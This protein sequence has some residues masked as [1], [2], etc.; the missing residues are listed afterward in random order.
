VLARLVWAL[1]LVV[2]WLRER[3]RRLRRP[4]ACV[5]FLLEAPPPEPEAPRPPL[6]QRATG[7]ARQPLSV[8]DLARQLRAVTAEPRVRTVVLHLR[9]LEMAAAQVDA[10]R[11]L[12]AEVRAAGVRVVCWAPSYSAS[13][14][15][16]A[17]AADEVLMQAGGT[18][19]PLG[20]ARE[21]VFLAD[22][23]D[24]LGLRVDLLQVSPY[25]T[26]GDALTRRGLTPEAREMAG[27]LAD[28]AY[29]DRLAAIASGRRLDDAGAR[30][31]ADDSPLVDDQ[32][33]AAG[34]VDALIAEEDLPERLG[35]EVRPWAAARRRLPRPRPR[36]PGRVVALLRIEGLIVDGRSRHAPFRLPLAPP[37]LF[38]EQCGDLTVVEQARALA[39]DR[40]VGAVVVWVDSGGG[41]A[42][43]SEAMAAALAALGRRKPVV[44]AMGAV[45]AS[46]G[47]YV[48]ASAA[49][50]FAH[51]GTVTGS[52]G[53]LAG[54][55]VA[56]RLLDHLLVGREHVVRGEH[57]AMW[58]AESPFTD[59][60]RRKLGE[61]IDRSYGLFLSRV[62]AARGRPVA[63]IEP[64]AGGRVWTGSQALRHGLV[65]E[66]GGLEAAVAAARRLGGLPDGAPVREA[67]QGRRE[68]VPAPATTA[69]ALEHALRAAAALRTAGAWWL[70]P[71]VSEAGS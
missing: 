48:T 16:V 36:P 60:E 12:V 40:R 47:Y 22:A 4:P 25:K 5:G 56:G 64:V 7:L 70:C 15:L 19:A 57:S 9:P 2:W 65:D 11:A 62:A 58:S 44:A 8:Q 49:R 51:P 37:L 67:R 29:A 27:W 17:C 21:Y 54:K 34:A 38:Q 53:V 33:V 52:I 23:L 24:R 59:A 26:A 1:R 45:A 3:V 42:T 35:G 63:E 61:L 6:W 66:L 13:T 39:L 68:L 30:R 55:L 32:A 50:V 31:L 18:V 43:A 46:G 14:Y 41:S 69:A 28:A 20:L 71:L 10:L